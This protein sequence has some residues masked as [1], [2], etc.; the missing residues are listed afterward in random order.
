VIAWGLEAK[1]A[2]P[3]AETMKCEWFKLFLEPKALRDESAVDP[4]LPLLPVS[5]PELIKCIHL[6]H[7][8][9]QENAPLI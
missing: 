4:R 7:G 1:N 8:N 9:S 2:G 5:I 3:M 6:N